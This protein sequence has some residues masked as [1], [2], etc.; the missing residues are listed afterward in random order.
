MASKHTVRLFDMQFITSCIS[1]MMVLILLGMMVFFVL[2]AHNL[3]VYV[4]ENLNFSILIS[5]DASETSILKFQKSLNQEPFVKESV[6]ISKEQALKENTEA[7]GSDPAEFLGYNPFS[8]SIELRLNADYANAD[9]VAWIKDRISQN[10]IVTEIDYQEGLMDSVNSNIRKLSLGL[11]VL[12]GLLTLVSFALIN[13]TIRL[14][15]YSKRFLIHTMKLVGA[16]WGFIRRP[17]LLRN[18]WVG[19]ISG[20]LADVVL[21][22]AAYALV[23]YEPSLLAIITAQTM[24][25]VMLSTL[26]FGVIIACLCAYVSINK[27]LRLSAGSL[28][29]M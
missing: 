3:S 21:I 17:F 29:Y 22:G 23:S 1:T 10:K 7:M 14:T 8:S 11:L 2:S 27:Y 26:V 15:I 12:A 19:F 16:S 18:F 4:R 9:S 25:W 28:Y 13:N 24:L 20:L 6:Y 5:D